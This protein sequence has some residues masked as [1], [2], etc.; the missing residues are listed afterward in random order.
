MRKK[1][2]GRIRTM[3][4]NCVLL[5]QVDESRLLFLNFFLHADAL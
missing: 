3:V 1:I 4:E 5:K 2:D